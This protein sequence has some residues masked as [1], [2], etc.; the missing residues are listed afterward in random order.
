MSTQAASDLDLLGSFC[1]LMHFGAGDVLRRKGQHYRD[2]YL[3]SNGCVEVDREASPDVAKPLV[4]QPGSP[5]GEIAFLRGCAATAT[6]TARASGTALVIDDATLAGLD[7]NVPDLT[8]RLLRRLAEIADER[9]S[10][11]LIFTP[12]A[13][14]KGQAIHV[15][16]CRNKEMLESAMRLRYEV[17]CQELGRRS[18]YADH[19]RKIITDD[20]DATAHVF[21]AVEGGQAIGTL[22]ANAACESSLGMFEELYGMKKSTRHPEAT[23]ICTKFIIRKSSRNGLAALKLM[24]AVAHYGLRHAIK[25]CYVDAIPMLLPYYKSV[26]FTIS[27]PQFLHRENGISYPMMIDLE[28]NG[29]RLTSERSLSGY[30]NLFVK[31]QAIRLLDRV[32][33]IR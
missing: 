27:G 15:Y 22:R 24:S 32:R 17:Y 4:S 1:R 11:N 21:I 31:A 7:R 16:L 14:A 3:I 6:V 9:T 12:G 18:P 20:L 33:G 25:E 28:R 10:E 19:E 23:A 30:V 26:G 29:D 8:A 5:I 13:Y 2:M